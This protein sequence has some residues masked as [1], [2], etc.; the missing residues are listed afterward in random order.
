MPFCRNNLRPARGRKYDVRFA[1]VS[2]SCETTYAPPGDENVDVIQTNA[3]IVETT[4][5][6]PGDE[7]VLIAHDSLSV[8]E[9]TY[10]PPG[11][12]NVS[13]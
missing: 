13:L 6:P 10:T 12:E 5:A 7:N 4:Y 11:D 8:I 1:D 3:R 9:T 2:D